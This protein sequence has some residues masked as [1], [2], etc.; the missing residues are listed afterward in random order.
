MSWPGKLVTSKVRSIETV[1]A[2]GK[3]ITGLSG[4]QPRAAA[5]QPPLH[6]AAAA[7]SVWQQRFLTEEDLVR[8][9][10]AEDHTVPDGTAARRAAAVMAATVMSTSPIESEPLDLTG[11]LDYPY[12]LALLSLPGVRLLNVGQPL[13][14]SGEPLGHRVVSVEASAQLPAFRGGLTRQASF[15]FSNAPLIATGAVASEP[16]SRAEEPALRP[17]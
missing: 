4:A 10:E 12:W 7:S 16:G 8:Q 2:P 5:D 17:V 1:R 11:G 14:R 15:A 6:I 13:L 9:E 3:R